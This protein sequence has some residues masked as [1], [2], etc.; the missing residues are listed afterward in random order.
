MEKQEM[1]RAVLDYEVRHGHNNE[2]KSLTAKLLSIYNGTTP[3]QEI[4]KAKERNR[5]RDDGARYE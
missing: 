5:V 3:D 1:I 2:R 4:A